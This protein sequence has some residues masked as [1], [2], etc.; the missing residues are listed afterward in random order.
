VNRERF[1]LRGFVPTKSRLISG[2]REERVRV[3]MAAD[4]GTSERFSEFVAIKGVDN[5]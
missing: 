5:E 1:G 3:L 2:G 4:F